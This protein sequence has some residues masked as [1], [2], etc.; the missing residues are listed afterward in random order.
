MPLATLSIIPLPC[1]STCMVI[2]DWSLFPLYCFPSPMYYMLNYY[3]PLQ[4]QKEAW[5][6]RV[7]VRDFGL[8]SNR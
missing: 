8:C 7:K 6:S 4:K 2:Y 5:D 1:R 3:Y